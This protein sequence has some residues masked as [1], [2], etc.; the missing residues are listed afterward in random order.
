M[1]ETDPFDALRKKSS[2]ITWYMHHNV[3]RKEEVLWLK[4]AFYQR[5]GYMPDFEN[6]RTFNEK[7]NWYRFNYDNPIIP[8]LI[9]KITFKDYIREQLGEGYTAIMFGYWEDEADIDF[10]NLPNR[11]V[12][13]SNNSG[14]SKKV[15]II[16]DKKNTDLD[17][18]RY[19]ITDWLL[20]WNS[21]SN[22]FSPW[23]KQIYPRI[24]AEEFLEQKGKPD[25]DD[26]KFFCFNGEPRFLYVYSERSTNKY[27]TFYDM[28]WNILPFNVDFEPHPYKI[29]KPESLNKMAELSRKLA[30]PFPF[31]RIDL[32]MIN[33][34][35]YVGEFTFLPLGGFHKFEP[36]EWDLKLG[37]Y[38]ILP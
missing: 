33:E 26:Y 22:S 28:D 23:H 6:P 13:K 20:P 4:R 10:D 24:L 9:D 34:K 2:Y 18:V 3:S 38:F 1:S 36:I 35:L 32:Y 15:M 11:F 21:Y 7:I 25:I 16:K 14:H 30:K 27:R 12:L 37:E 5:V 29:S 8:S 19:E 17:R 31:V